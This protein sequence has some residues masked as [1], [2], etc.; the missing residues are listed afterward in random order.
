MYRLDYAMSQLQ[1]ILFMWNRKLTLRLLLWE[2]P[3]LVCP[4]WVSL[5][6][7][8]SSSGCSPRWSP[9]SLRRG[10]L[11]GVVGRRGGSSWTRQR[12]TVGHIPRTSHPGKRHL[13]VH[14]ID[15]S[16]LGYL[17]CSKYYSYWFTLHSKHVS[18]KNARSTIRRQTLFEFWR[19]ILW[20]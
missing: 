20:L 16:T 14:V 7:P 2:Q 9:E 15:F 10:R 17:N 13:K 19:N 6:S 3:G 5:L 18:L 4:G 12:G 1:D 8:S 11:R